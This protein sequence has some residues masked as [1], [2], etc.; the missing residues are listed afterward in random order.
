MSKGYSDAQRR[1]T[2][3]YIKNNYD[4]FKVRFPK[5]KKEEYKKLAQSK[6]KGLNRLINELLEKENAGEIATPPVTKS[7]SDFFE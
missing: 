6:G 5:G 7:L 3:K 1:A 2:E 4:E